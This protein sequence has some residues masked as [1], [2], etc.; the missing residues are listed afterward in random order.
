M[1]LILSVVYGSAVLNG[2]EMKE[3]EPTAG[4]VDDLSVKLMQ[5]VEE[6]YKNGENRYFYPQMSSQERY[7]LYYQMCKWAFCEEKSCT[8]CCINSPGV[9]KEFIE[10]FMCSRQV[11]CNEEAIESKG[12]SPNV[13]KDMKEKLEKLQK[14]DLDNYLVYRNDANPEKECRQ[15]LLC[16]TCP[17]VIR[18][19]REMIGLA[20]AWFLAS[21]PVPKEVFQYMSTGVPK[22]APDELVRN[23]ALNRMIPVCALGC[24]GFICM[25]M[26]TKLCVTLENL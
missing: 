1:A 26:T 25:C 7:D 16:D 13:V 6:K 11:T 18:S 9:G 23:Y 14:K 19:S 4:K 3:E 21:G 24:S 17:P 12:L 22:N 5:M 10:E 2:M 15:C 20:C 8:F